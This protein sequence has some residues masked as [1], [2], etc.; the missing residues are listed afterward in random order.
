MRAEP[1]HLDGFHT[2][3]SQR[4]AQTGWLSRE[5]TLALVLIIVTA[6]AFYLC[7]RLAYPLLPALGWALALAVVTYPLYEW[8]AFRVRH[9]NLAAGLTVVLVALTIVGPAVF[10]TQRLVRE[11]ATGVERLQTEAAT[12]RWRVLIERN[13]R[14]APVL[15]WAETQ[16]D[17]RGGAKQAATAVTSRL[18]SFVTGSVWAAAGLLITLFFLFYFFRDRRAALQALRSLV[19]L[20]EAETTKVFA[21]VADTIHAT[22]YGTL[23]VALVQGTLGGLMFWALGLPSPLIW[24]AV[25]AVLAVVPV[26][27]TFVVW[28]PAAL[29]LALEGNWGKALILTTWGGVAIALVDNLLY[30]TLVG[31][32]LRLHT[33]PVFVALIGGLALFGAVGLVLGPVILA[34]TVALVDVWRRRTAGGHT[35][36]EGV[37]A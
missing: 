34:V 7:Y 23:V 18:P 31:Q 6:L 5:R 26:L 13:P 19:P 29:F 8:I 3:E 9:V 11:V 16:T 22:I 2:P 25:M 27:G 36:E 12:G 37:T 30:P 28:V 24:G 15:R 10:V 17:L 4:E 32:R 14:L 1:S 33:L 21:R 20:S 35:A